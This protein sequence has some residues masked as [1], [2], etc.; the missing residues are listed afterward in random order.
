MQT[1]TNLTI[2][3]NVVR[4]N[5]G[6]HVRVKAPVDSAVDYFSRYQQHDFTIHAVVDG[7]KIFLDFACGFPGSMHDAT[8]LRYSMLF[9]RV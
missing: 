9:R 7:Q 5:D 8:V 1:F 3:P 2:L 6:S 4:A